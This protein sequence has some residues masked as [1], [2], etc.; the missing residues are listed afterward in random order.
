MNFFSQIFSPF[1]Y[2]NHFI[3]F[4][5]KRSRLKLKTL[6]AEGFTIEYW[7]SKNKKPYLL[8]LQAFAAESKYSWH[9]QIYS[10]SKK[11]HLIIPNLIYF[12]GSTMEDKSYSLADQVNAIQVLIDHL[13]LETYSI[14]GASYGGL[15]A[16]SIADKNQSKI[17]KLI[18]TNAPVKYDSLADIKAILDDF[19]LQTKA[20]LL[21]PEN[22]RQLHKL[23]GISYYRAPPVPAFLFKSIHKNQYANSADKRKLVEK[24]ID[25]LEHLRSKNYAFDFPVL[26]IWGEED[27]LTPVRIGINLNE[28]LGKKS[29]LVIIPKTAHMPN[30]E[31]PRRYNQL[32][33]AFLDE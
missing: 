17:Q 1:F 20:Q 23:F 18:L 14:S 15:I 26:L 9:K 30:L 8:L 11:Y 29:R 32:M 25:D 4:K 27:R 16:V 24:S 6:R 10:L 3:E 13:K 2:F 28:H 33:K 19:G 22:Y 5:F 31:K 12:G 21:V 7:Q